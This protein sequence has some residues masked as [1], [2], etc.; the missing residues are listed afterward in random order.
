APAPR[1]VTPRVLVCHCV[2]PVPVLMSA[3]IQRSETAVSLS[4]T[5]CGEL[6][7]ACR[8]VYDDG[9]P[10]LH[11]VALDRGGGCSRRGEP[12]DSARAPASGCSPTDD[13]SQGTS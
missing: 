9:S 2:E 5:R 13:R 6:E 4:A 7:R 10:D 11:E 3:D 1:V 8:S 12:V